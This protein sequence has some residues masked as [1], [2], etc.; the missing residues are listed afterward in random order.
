GGVRALDD[1]SFEVMP[2][3]VHCLAGENGSGKSTLIK[4]ITG[5]Y[6]P[7]AGAEMEYFGERVESV[8]PNQARRLGIDVI[9]QDLALFPQMSVAE[10]FAFEE[11]LGGRPRFVRRNALKAKAAR[12]L[13]RLGVTLDLDAPLNTLSIAERQIVAVCRALV[14]EARLV[15][16]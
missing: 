1:V 15:F 16:M 9:W 8:S 7:D 13:A 11:I 3:E 12:V 2:G 10:N 14:G 6:T 4:V 5:V